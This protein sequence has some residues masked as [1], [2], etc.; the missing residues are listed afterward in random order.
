MPK[1]LPFLRISIHS[2]VAKPMSG[3]AKSACPMRACISAPIGVPWGIGPQEQQVAMAECNGPQMGAKA[4][5]TSSIPNGMIIPQAPTMTL[6]LRLKPLAA[7][8]QASR[9]ST[10]T[11]KTNGN[12]AF[13]M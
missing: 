6:R 12:P 3:F 9:A 10:T 2:L 8:A 13:G 1:T 4:L 5:V 7:K 11:P